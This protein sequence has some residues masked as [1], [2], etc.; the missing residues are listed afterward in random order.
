GPAAAALRRAIPPG[1]FQRLSVAGRKVVV[2]GAHN[3]EGVAALVREFAGRP[4]DVCV[5]AFMSDKSG[6]TL[7]AALSSAARR[8]ILTR[9]FSYRSAPPLEIRGQMPPALRGGTLVMDSPM[10]ALARAVK[11][12]PEGGTVLVAG[13]LY[14]AGDVLAGLRG[15][16]AF[17]PR[18]MPVKAD[19]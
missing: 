19:A 1:R 9:S 8:L 2:D 3:A 18:E 17:H 12:A 5:A 16:R 7:A 13:S 11:L 4:A 14:L 6:G 10:K 15:H